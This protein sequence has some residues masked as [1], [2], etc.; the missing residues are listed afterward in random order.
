[1]T[2]ITL[3]AGLENLKKLDLCNLQVADITPLANLRM[4]KQLRLQGTQVAPAQIASLERHL[5][6]LIV[7][8]I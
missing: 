1:M 3:L 4:L 2:D 6:D 8:S 7:E 5:P